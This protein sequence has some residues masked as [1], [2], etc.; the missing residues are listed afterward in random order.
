MLGFA[1]FLNAGQAYCDRSHDSKV[2]GETRKY[3]IFLP[4]DYE[5]SAKRYPVVFYFHGHSDRYTL[6]GYDAGLDTVPKIASFVAEHDVIVVAADGYVARDYTGFYGGTPY[7]VR[8]SGGEFDYGQY[9]L[10]S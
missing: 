7:D 9:F 5:S 4:P 10:V 1:G 6:E 3:R 8:R 2:F